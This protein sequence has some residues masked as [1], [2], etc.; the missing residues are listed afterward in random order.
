MR[1][2]AFVTFQYGKN[3]I[4]K[5]KERTA[6]CELCSE[7]NAMIF[8]ALGAN[9]PSPFGL[10]H[11]TMRWAVLQLHAYGIEVVQ[12]SRVYI[13]EPVPISAQPYYYN[14]VVQVNTRLS[15][16][17]VMRFLLEIET[18]TGRQ[19]REINASRPLDLDIIAY[20]NSHI[21]TQMVHIPHP[22]MH[23]RLFVLR[24]IQDIASHW[25]HPTLQL[26]VQQMIASAPQYYCEPL[27][28]MPQVMGVLNVTPDSFSDGGQFDG[29]E[30]ALVQAVTMMDEGA[31]CIDIGG[32]STR[33]NA[34]EISPHDEQAR[35]VPVLKQLVP[36]AHAR[37]RRISVDTRHASTMEAVI[38]L[39]VD[40]IN[41]VSALTHDDRSLDVVAQS[42]A[43]VILMHMRGTPATMMSLAHYDNVV[44][45]VHRYFEQRIAACEAAGIAPSRITLDPG[46]G[47]AKTAAHNM[48]LIHNI[49]HLKTLGCP[50]LIG[51][52][53]KSMIARIAGECDAQQRIGGSVAL[54]LQAQTH[55][56][57]WLRVHDV[58][59]TQ[60]A[61][62]LNAALTAN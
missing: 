28:H 58:Q 55:G 8:I 61:L 34:P 42:R 51:A 31:F 32:E 22:R 26:S 30:A 48:Q 60:Q 10:P 36:L 14:Q 16:D 23:E 52:S 27:G 53:R 29:T 50:V 47:F 6:C 19:R 12:Q 20:D 25:V 17:A 54:A 1:R 56:A 37:G 7:R 62:I 9:T 46:L 57:N 24:P 44:M 38:K 18:R 43:D 39:G 3:S 21:I 11:Q 35:I 13:T 15:P 5:R 2:I 41:D 49:A 59:V 33:P 45:D 40:I 4:N